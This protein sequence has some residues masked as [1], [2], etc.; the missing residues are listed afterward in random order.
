MVSTKIAVI[1]GVIFLIASVDLIVNSSS[2]D[3]SDFITQ[4]KSNNWEDRAK[5]FYTIHSIDSSPDAKEIKAALL[6]LLDRENQLIESTLKE[7][8]GEKGVSVKYGEGYS[9]YYSDLLRFVEKQSDLSDKRTLSIIV[10]GG[11]DP[12]SVFAQ[13]LMNRGEEIVPILMEMHKSD[14]YGARYNSVMMLGQLVGR[15]RS[16]VSDQT[17]DQIMQILIASQF[18]SNPMVKAGA[19]KSLQRLGKKND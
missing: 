6:D 18:D 13:K 11:Y 2:Q 8:N 15:Y 1:L 16:K 17:A 9:E 12:E 4:L 7:S 14:L 10:H 19:I 3:Q 5:A